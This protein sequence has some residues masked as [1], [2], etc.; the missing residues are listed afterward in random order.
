MTLVIPAPH[1]N[2]RAGIR[3]MG[4]GQTDEQHHT[5]RTPARRTKGGLSWLG[6]HIPTPDEDGPTIVAVATLVAS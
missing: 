3:K 5:E 4:V 1:F 6:I 2:V